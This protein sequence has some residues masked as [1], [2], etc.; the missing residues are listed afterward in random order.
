VLK[1]S[2]SRPEINPFVKEPNATEAIAVRPSKATKKYSDG[3]N[4]SETVANGGARSKSTRPLINP[5]T[6]EANAEIRIA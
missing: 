6:T 1:K 4:H 5:P 3:P 2:P